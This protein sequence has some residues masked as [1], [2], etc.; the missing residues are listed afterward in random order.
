MYPSDFQLLQFRHYDA[1][2]Q[3]LED[4]ALELIPPSTALSV[5]LAKRDRISIDEWVDSVLSL[6]HT[7]DEDERATQIDIYCS[8]VR[9]G[10][11]GNWWGGDTDACL[12]S[13]T[14]P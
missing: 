6:L 3:A 12:D 4:E 5:I 11:G 1:S 8:W 14:N 9:Y 7:Q 10:Y 2:F 13:F